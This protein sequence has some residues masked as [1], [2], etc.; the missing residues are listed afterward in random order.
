MWQSG[1]KLLAVGPVSAVP[2]FRPEATVVGQGQN[3]VL[4]VNS[5][6]IG[7]SSAMIGSAKV[8]L[9]GKVV[10][11]LKTLLTVD[12]HGSILSDELA[13]SDVQE[14]GYTAYSP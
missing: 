8:S 12:C 6:R 11:K 1:T 14:H 7:I 9:R 4:A 10:H 2:A 5:L 13:G 3:A